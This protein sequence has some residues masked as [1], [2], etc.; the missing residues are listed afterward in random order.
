MFWCSC[1]RNLLAFGWHVTLVARNAA[2]AHVLTVNV[3]CRTKS[4]TADST[5]ERVTENHGA[6]SLLG[7]ALF[8]FAVPLLPLFSACFVARSFPVL[9]T[10]AVPTSTITFS[11]F[12]AWAN[13]IV[14]IAVRNC[15]LFAVV[16][17]CRAPLF[18]H[19]H[20][21]NKKKKTQ[22]HVNNWV[23]RTRHPPKTF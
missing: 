15:V 23:T 20:D 7:H 10:N 16:R 6:P 11:A 4:R 21:S 5:A 17:D 22:T 8:A 1:K 3:T 2:F 14:G 9:F 18:S 19:T 12:G 13:P